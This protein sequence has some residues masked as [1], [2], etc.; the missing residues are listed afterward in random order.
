MAVLAE[1]EML[2]QPWQQDPADAD[3]APLSPG[4][5]VVVGAYAGYEAVRQV[6][7]V[8]LQVPRMAN[9]D[10]AFHCVRVASKRAVNDNKAALSRWTAVCRQL[11]VDMSVGSMQTPNKMFSDCIKCFF[12]PCTKSHWP[13]LHACFCSAIADAGA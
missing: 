9:I 1:G 4:W 5:K 7:Q 8:R 11:P 12:S 2:A 10:F 13:V 3:V 6:V